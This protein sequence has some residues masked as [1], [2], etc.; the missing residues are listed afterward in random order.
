M[1]TSISM[2]VLFSLSPI[3]ISGLLLWIV[4]SVRTC[5]FH[6]MVTFPPLR[7]FYWFWHM[8]VPVYCIQLRSHF[9]TDGSATIINI[10]VAVMQLISTQLEFISPTLNITNAD[11]KASTRTHVNSKL[12]KL[13]NEKFKKE[14][15]NGRCR[16]GQPRRRSCGT[17]TLTPEVTC[18]RWLKMP[19]IIAESV[20]MK[21]CIC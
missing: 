9:L 16:K 7:Y 17:W 4:L 8:F 18:I 15:K 3:I 21:Q 12:K 13:K 11:Y 2:H 14:K 1:A 6:N 10:V 19:Q 5:W 20:S